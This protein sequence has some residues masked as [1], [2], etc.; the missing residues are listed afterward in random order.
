MRRIFGPK[1]NEYDAEWQQPYNYYERVLYSSPD[2]V[3]N[4]EIAK[5]TLYR[6]SCN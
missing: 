3:R 4:H 1:R 2:T 5:T 6:T